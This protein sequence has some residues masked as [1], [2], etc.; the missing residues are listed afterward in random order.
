M[1]AKEGR[2][3]KR[4]KQIAWIVVLLFVGS[5][6]LFPNLYIPKEWRATANELL[7][8]DWLCWNDDLFEGSFPFWQQGASLEVQL[9]PEYTTLYCVAITFG[10]PN[11][12][13]KFF[14]DGKLDAELLRGG[15]V[16]ETITLLPSVVDTVYW[17]DKITIRPFFFYLPLTVIEPNKELQ[18]YADSMIVRI[19]SGFTE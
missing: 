3:K 9:K 7:I 1:T 16:M 6:F 18:Q 10:I 17:T 4:I 11:P 8:G 12:P 13:H 15:E 5:L 2:M 14:Y 19:E